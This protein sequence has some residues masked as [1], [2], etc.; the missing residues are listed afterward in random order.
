MH[1]QYV[2]F[3]FTAFLVCTNIMRRITEKRSFL[4][5][6]SYISPGLHSIFSFIKWIQWDAGVTHLE[7]P[8]CKHMN[9]QKRHIDYKTLILSQNTM[10]D[11]AERDL[12]LQKESLTFLIHHVAWKDQFTFVLSLASAQ[13]YF[14]AELRGRPSSLPFHNMP[15]FRLR[16]LP[17]SGASRLRLHFCFRKTGH[18]QS[19]NV[20]IPVLQ[21]LSDLLE[22]SVAL[23]KNW[24][25]FGEK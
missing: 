10:S 11:T 8:S 23:W 4:R 7:T 9:W 24:C 22:G 15:I 20:F 6:V 13:A 5:G 12:A 17:A 25:D 14:R 1:I 21:Y 19:L 3:L 2:A 18:F 16:N